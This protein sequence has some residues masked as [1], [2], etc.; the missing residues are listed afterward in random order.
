MF[1]P[2]II[3]KTKM[4][5]WKLGWHSWPRGHRELL[6]TQIGILDPDLWIIN[7]HKKYFE[8]ARFVLYLSSQLTLTII[9]LTRQFKHLQLLFMCAQMPWIWKIWIFFIEIARARTKTMQQLVSKRGLWDPHH[10]HY[11]LQYGQ[12]SE[13]N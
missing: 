4:K 8:F 5:F 11:S 3:T 13:E 10:T 7:L 2:D 9:M 12:G 6:L 1:K